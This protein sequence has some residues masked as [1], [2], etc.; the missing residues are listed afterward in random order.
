MNEQINNGCSNGRFSVLLRFP[1]FPSPYSF[2]GSYKG[3]NRLPWRNRE[4]G[5]FGGYV[6]MVCVS[7]RGNIISA[8]VRSCP[9]KKKKIRLDV[10]TFSVGNYNGMQFMPHVSQTILLNACKYMCQTQTHT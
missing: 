7:C 6:S 8:E 9:E 1:L 10:K 2:Q 5:T 3:Q 4:F